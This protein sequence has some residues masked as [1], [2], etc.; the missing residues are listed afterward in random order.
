ML[1]IADSNVNIDPTLDEIVAI[2]RLA[3]EEVRRFGLTPK[4]ALLSPSN[5]GSSAAPSA[6]K[7]REAVQRLQE[8]LPDIEIA[9]EMKADAATSDAI[10][11]TPMP[12]T[13][14]QR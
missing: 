7:M 9:G 10:T 14:R 4:I 11:D 8:M 1:F 13:H 12:T 5:F 3:A 6:R 2:A